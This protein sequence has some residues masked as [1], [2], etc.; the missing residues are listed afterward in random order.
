MSPNLFACLSASVWCMMI[1]K[2]HIVLNNVEIFKYAEIKMWFS[3]WLN[4]LIKLGSCYFM[5]HDSLLA[6]F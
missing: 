5:E 4:P 1:G 6:L 3:D 2:I